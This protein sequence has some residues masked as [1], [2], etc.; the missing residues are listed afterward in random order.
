MKQLMGEFSSVSKFYS[1]LSTWAKIL[2][3]CIL[4]LLVVSI[5]KY[6]NSRKE[7]YEERSTFTSKINT[8]VYDN[9]YVDVYDSLV[10]NNMKDDYEI[11]EIV[12]KTTPTSESIFLDIG[13]GTGHHVSKLTDMGF[14]A[15]GMDSSNDMV[16]K[17]KENYPSCRFIH[18]DITKNL[19][20]NYSSYT[21]VLC[22]YFT[23]YYMKD[24]ERFF[25]NCFN[26]LMPGG[27]LI[28]HLVDRET[29]DPILP[30]GQAFIV[31]SP[32]KYAKK[33]IT[34]TK[35]HF[36]DFVYTA[37]FNLNP[38]TNTALFNEKFKFKENGH[39][40][41]NQHIMYMEPIDT[42]TTYA[43]NAG[44]LIDDKVDLLH[45]GYD[46]QYLYIL[47]KPN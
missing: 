23:I 41:S 15:I 29:F 31:V 10:Y 44:F 5:F 30:A 17:S 7:G 6:L 16:N 4:L 25:E 20:S 13:S 24:K 42:I 22:L 37:D 35:V 34:T 12:N 47:T 45:C 1:N 46:N 40:R 26:L 33:R 36:D 32:Q 11:G 38:E 18:G 3:F 27:Y 19:T 8:E 14:N 21:H 28:I 2:Y 43:Q 9:F 39:V